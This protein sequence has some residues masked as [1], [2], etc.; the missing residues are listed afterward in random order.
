MTASKRSCETST[1]IMPK[2][3]NLL[4]EECIPVGRIPACTGQGCVSAWGVSA[5]GGV[6]LGGCLPGGSAHGGL[7]AQGGV[8]PR[9][10]WQTPPPL[11]TDRHLWK[12]N[13][14]KLRLRA[15][16]ILESCT[17]QWHSCNC[18]SKMSKIP[19]NCTRFFWNSCSSSQLVLFV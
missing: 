2:L 1:R 14:R 12:H 8:C 3:W 16:V 15:V 6:C 18:T 10:G 5:W 13:L 11:W 19:L 17:F 9:R 7:S 4:Q